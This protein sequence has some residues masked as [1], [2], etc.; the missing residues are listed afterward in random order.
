MSRTNRI[1]AHEEK[2]LAI[3]AKAESS[4]T[5]FIKLVSPNRVLGACHDELI[6][7]W[8]R[9]EKKTHQLTLLPRDHGKSAMVA[10]RV[11]WY[12]TKNPDIRVLYISSTSNLAEKQLKFIKDILESPIY[13]IYWPEMIEEEE[14]KRERWTLSEISVDHPK[15]KQEGVRD[16]TIFAAGL[17]TAVTGMHCDIA[18]LDDV[19]VKENA[20]TKDGRD[21][22]RE[23]YSLIASI[24]SADSLEWVVGTRYHPDDLY[25]SMLEM[26]EDIYD[27]E[28]N[29]VSSKP[30]YEIW[31]RQV[32]DRGDGTGQFLW[33]RQQ[34]YDGKWFGFNREILAKKRAQYLDKTQFRAQYYNNPNDPEGDGIRRDYFQYY[35]TKYVKR[36]N[37]KWFFKGVPLN[38]F[39]SADLAY[40]APNAK[41][42]YTAIVVVGV[43]PNN[44]YYVLDIDRFQTDSIKEHFSHILSMHNKWDFRKLRIEVNSSQKSIV[45]ELKDVYIR[46]E[47]LAL[48]LDEFSPTRHLG[49]KEERIAA[50]LQPRY[51]NRAIW[52]YQG[53]N[54]QILEDELVLSR[55]PHDDVKDA[56]ASCIEICVAPTGSRQRLAST[57]SNI[58][59][60]PRF[61]GV[62]YR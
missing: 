8:E 38:I 18:V 47:G 48:S 29:L 13:R 43:D 10:Y 44:N 31:E 4:L 15:R 56:L 57:Q 39:A 7:W 60:H 59:T 17:T 5:D 49:Q 54:C 27:E 46:G 40:S 33:P 58:I 30:I 36:D 6:Q 22:V 20:Y 11:A 14:N 42:D 52:H 61:G 28:G 9:E 34:R 21:K 12:I 51:E 16:P 2:R 45:K 32:E 55:S 41:R 3:R 35:D 25:N 62:S 26:E 1:S 24:E 19:I 37:G 23:Q 53:G 50:A